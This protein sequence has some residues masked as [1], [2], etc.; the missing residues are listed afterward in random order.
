MSAKGISLNSR[1]MFVTYHHFLNS[2]YT[3]PDHMLFE[4]YVGE[5]IK[6]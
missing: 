4:V 1:F 3:Q 6:S 5:V 2:R